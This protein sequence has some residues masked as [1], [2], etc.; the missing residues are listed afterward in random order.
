MERSWPGNG[1]ALRPSS[2]RHED[3]IAPT[4]AFINDEVV[5]H[6][7]TRTN[8]DSGNPAPLP[9]VG[10]DFN[11][12]IQARLDRRQF[13][14]GTLNAAAQWVFFANLDLSAKEAARESLLGFS[15]IPVSHADEVIVPPGY[16]WHVV[17]A[18]G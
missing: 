4:K 6:L 17:S 9:P 3:R 13:L 5:L 12:L 8:D 18:W 11:Q 7:P 1:L 2:K 14:H 15:S 16:S 10:N